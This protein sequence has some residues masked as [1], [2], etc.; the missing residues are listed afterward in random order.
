MATYASWWETYGEEELRSMYM[1]NKKRKGKKV[2]EP[3]KEVK[4]PKRVR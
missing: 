2:K 3:K 1:G 4:K